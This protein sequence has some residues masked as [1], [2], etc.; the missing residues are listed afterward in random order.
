VVRRKDE[1]EAREYRESPAIRAKGEENMKCV[2]GEEIPE[3]I[4]AFFLEDEA[5]RADEVQTS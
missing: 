3:T 2:V 5:E 4:D 1:G